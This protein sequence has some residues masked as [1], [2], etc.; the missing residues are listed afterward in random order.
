[1]KL[2]HTRAIITAALNDDFKDVKFK[3]HPI[4]KL[5]M[6]ITCPNVP[7]EIYILEWHENKDNYDEKAQ[8]LANKFNENFKKFKEYAN[9][10]ILNAAPRISVGV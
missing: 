2:R 5:Y 10:E 4:F 6:P 3:K 9:D 7:N 1:M 8:F